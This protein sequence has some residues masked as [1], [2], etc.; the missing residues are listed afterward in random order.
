MSTT[1]EKQRRLQNLLSTGNLAANYASAKKLKEISNM[2]KLKLEEERKQTKLTEKITREEILAKR[3]L[4]RQQEEINR[5]KLAQMQKQEEEEKQK[6]ILK[7]I[8]FNLT[9]ELNDLK[10]SKKST[11]EKY[12]SLLSIN[13]N[14]KS[15]KI[16]TSMTEDYKEKKMIK[17]FI[18]NL[19]DEIEKTKDKF[20]KDDEKDLKTIIDILETD[21]ETK[22]NKIKESNKFKKFIQYEDERNII[23]H[24]TDIFYLTGK[25][26][27][28]LKNL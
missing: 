13:S 6:K 26:G 5:R 4:T 3:K 18:N 10:K 21:E 12:F 22:I 15:Y 7:E 8:F 20:T 28:N 9:E 2:I 1:P 19:N 25:Y 17:D 27:K 11:L 16:S 23:K 14:L 24:S